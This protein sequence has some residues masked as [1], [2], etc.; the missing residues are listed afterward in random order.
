VTNKD[1]QAS[2]TGDFAITMVTDSQ[3][4]QAMIAALQGRPWLAI[5]TE[6]AREKVYYPRL[7]LIQIADEEQVF[8]VDPL[9]IDDLAPLWSLLCDTGVLKVFHAA[10][11]D[12]EVIYHVSGKVPGPVFDTQIAAAV[13]QQKEQVGY[14]ALVHEELGVTLHKA[15]TRADW[16]VRPLADELIQYAADDVIYLG[17]IYQSQKRQLEALDRLGWVEDECDLLLDIDNYIVH[18]EQAWRRVKEHRRLKGIQLAVLKS[19]AAWREQQAVAEDKP[20]KWIVGDDGLVELA[21]RMPRDAGSLNKL[22]TVK[23]PVVN[24]YGEAL[25]KAVAE[26]CEMDKADW[27]RLEDKVRIT[28]EQEA[29]VDLMM[30]A[31]K[32]IASEQGLAPSFLA[33]RK[34][35]E[36]YVQ[37]A[38]EEVFH[39]WRR[40]L[41]A[42]PL[43]ALFSGR[44]VIGCSPAGR[45][46]LMPNTG[47]R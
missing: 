2:E 15:H 11:Q 10:R 6:F 18:P 21:R 47:N 7:C 25:L 8:C 42:E 24:R 27:P 5:D 44:S 29:L 3:G 39:G 46:A 28:P 35:L 32:L 30:C 12:L 41:L 19:A 17:R 34:H 31:V 33:N 40:R 37:S 43:Q 14:G 23:K 45:V 26:G 38:D 9:A 22:H 1:K 36:Q 4:L 13:V 16:S 20:R